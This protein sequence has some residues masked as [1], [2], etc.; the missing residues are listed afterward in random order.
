MTAS[1][2][3][4]AIIRLSSVGDVI[5]ALPALEALRAAYPDARISWIVERRA[6]NI[7]DG[8]PAIDEIIEFPRHEWKER[9]KRRFGLVRSLPAIRRFK[10]SLR[11][12]SFDL[13]IDFQGNLKSGFCTWACGARVRLGYA[14]EQ[15][16]EPNYLFTNRRV[17]IGG[18]DIHRVERDL[19]LVRDVGAPFEVRPHRIHFSDAD[20]EAGDATIPTPHQ[21]PP[22]A[23]LH[24]GTSDFMPHKR[25]PIEHYAAL[26]DALV[27]E[28]G[29]RVLLSWGPGEEE[30]IKAVRQ[31]MREPAEVIPLTPSMKSLGY[32]LS[33]SDLVVGGDTGPVHLAEVLGVPVIGIMGPSDPRH[34]YPLGHPERAFYRRLPCSPCRHRS[35]DTLQCLVDVRP[36]EV[37]ECALG[38]LAS[39]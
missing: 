36:R 39:R 7:L 31:A 16:R 1:F 20:R 14:R 3:N 27:R 13:T 35:C 11:K 26:G 18:Q 24:P 37:T 19:L 29:A 28:G 34:Y 38:I 15:C 6:R 22:V 4:I 23:V 10:R 2:E 17:G 30:R 9:W 21:G 5:V 8:H 32:L 25:W 33:L 12:R